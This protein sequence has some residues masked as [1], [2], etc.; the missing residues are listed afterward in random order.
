MH[1]GM[2]QVEAGAE[3]VLV[4]V[5]VERE[6]WSDVGPVHAFVEAFDRA[7]QFRHAGN[8]IG[9]WLATNDTIASLLAATV[10]TPATENLPAAR[11]RMPKTMRDDLKHL[12]A[13]LNLRHTLSD[14]RTILAFAQSLAKWLESSDLADEVDSL[15]T[16]LEADR[17]WN[18]RDVARW[19][20]PYVRPGVLWRGQPPA[21]YAAEGFWEFASQTRITRFVDLRGTNERL[22][23][24][25]PEHVIG[26][27][28]VPIEADPRAEHEDFDASYRRMPLRARP[29][30]EAVL[31][32]IA[33]SDGPVVVH[34]RAGV[35]RTGV[36]VA[37]IG[38]WLGVPHERVIADYL[39]S[40][41]L[42]EARRLHAALEVAEQHGID[43]LFANVPSEVV[44]TVRRRFF[45]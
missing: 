18:L 25:Y 26:C 5:D 7:V 33:E 43:E 38:R 24:P 3:A 28:S 22:E 1:G 30:L 6:T 40:G 14:L 17:F 19:W 12:R 39:A 27:T 42:V 34:C 4:E 32:A 2:S 37:L 45:N 35:D 13:G 8:S 10:G 20:A 23:D 44:H 29:A 31:E 15:S 11:S 9:C 21:A 36:I 41:Q 16:T